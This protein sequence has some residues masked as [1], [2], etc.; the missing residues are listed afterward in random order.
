MA[1]HSRGSRFLKNIAMTSSSVLPPLPSPEWEGRRILLASNSPRR[2]ELLGMIVPRFEIADSRLAKETYPDDLAAESVPEYLS[3][4][5]AEAHIPFIDD[6]E[7][8]IT[9]DTVVIADGRILG[10]PTDPADAKSMLQLLSGTTHKV[11]TGVT[12]ASAD[13]KKLS[14]S[15]HTLVTFAPMSEADIDSYIERFRPFDKAGSYG[16]QEW[17]GAAFICRIDGCYYNV[18]GLPLH[19]LFTHLREFL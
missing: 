6:D 1:H 7:V 10:K 17:I 3:R 15:E 12:I 8:V 18:M 13:G 4:Q 19:S 16:I 2:R 11:V 9:A 5:K 14:F